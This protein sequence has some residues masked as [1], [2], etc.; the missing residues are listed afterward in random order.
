MRL[1]KLSNVVEN[2]NPE[3]LKGAVPETQSQEYWLIPA[4]KLENYMKNGA[5]RVLRMVSS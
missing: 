5:L 1:R 2:S 4:A 3:G